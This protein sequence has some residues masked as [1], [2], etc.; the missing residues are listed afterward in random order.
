MDFKI[1]EKIQ[2]DI[3]ELDKLKTIKMENG[4]SYRIPYTEND[5]GIFLEYQAQ[6]LAAQA[7]FL[8]EILKELTK[9]TENKE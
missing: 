4:E 7:D 2:K 6:I 8:S 3:K 5:V 1:L 9:L